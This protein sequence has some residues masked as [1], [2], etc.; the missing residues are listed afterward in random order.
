MAF[1][2]DAEMLKSAC[3]KSIASFPQGNIIF[4]F[5]TNFDLL[6]NIDEIR[7]FDLDCSQWFTGCFFST[8]VGEI[9]SYENPKNKIIAIPAPDEEIWGATFKVKQIKELGILLSLNTL[10]I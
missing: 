5:A 6:I 9:Q 1:S 4:N 2:D 7:V 8:T 10:F 3:G